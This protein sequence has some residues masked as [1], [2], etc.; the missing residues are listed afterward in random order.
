[1]IWRNADLLDLAEYPF[2]RIREKYRFP[3]AQINVGFMNDDEFKYLSV[4]Y[5]S[6]LNHNNIWIYIKDD[7]LD[8]FAKDEFK[9]IKEYINA[10]TKIHDN[11]VE[12]KA[13]SKAKPKPKK[14]RKLKSF[15][16]SYFGG[17]QRIAKEIVEYIHSQYPERKIF[18]D[19]FGGGGSVAL[20]AAQSGYYDIV[21]Y[22]E[23]NPDLVRLA[24]A[25]CD[26]TFE[27]PYIRETLNKD[28]WRWRFEY[29]YNEKKGKR[30]PY[31]QILLS[32]FGYNGH[33]NKWIGKITE[34]QFKTMY[35]FAERIKHFKLDNLIITNKSYNELDIYN[36]AVVYCDIPYYRR[37]GIYE[38]DF[39]EK[40][41]DNFYQW[42]RENNCP[43]FV[44]EYRNEKSKQ[45]KLKVRWEKEEEV[46]YQWNGKKTT[47]KQAKK[48]RR[49]NRVF[50]S[51]MEIKSVVNYAFEPDKFPLDYIKE[52]WLPFIEYIHELKDRGASR[53]KLNSNTGKLVRNYIY[54]KLL[55]ENERKLYNNSSYLDVTKLNISDCWIAYLVKKDKSINKVHCVQLREIEPLILNWSKT[56]TKIAA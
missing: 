28:T 16:P 1:V 21:I 17:K 2:S 9:R 25:I 45:Y 30:E 54:E 55:S 47:I 43:V 19:V 18:V 6:N 27:M 53:S 8:S 51:S 40:D 31:Q 50:Q 13:K 12:L 15:M 7:D 49:M 39:K 10:K 48:I 44:S 4:K 26:G 37:K 29:M 5:G 24:Q 23:V 14:P 36:N 46:I 11:A 32:N 35:N 20:Y 56:K 33:I 42:V 38:Y 34:P 52:E 22:N 41:Y 3:L